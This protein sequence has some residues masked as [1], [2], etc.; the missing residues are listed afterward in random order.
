[1]AR[2][3]AIFFYS[4]PSVNKTTPTLPYPVPRRS[5]CLTWS[6]GLTGSSCLMLMSWRAESRRSSS[7][8]FLKKHSIEAASKLGAD[9][10]DR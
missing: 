5:P 6:T 2:I 10:S 1:M 8:H 7:Q 4:F 3:D 9:A